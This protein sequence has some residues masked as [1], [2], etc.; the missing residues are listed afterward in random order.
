MLLATVATVAVATTALVIRSVARAQ[1]G[2]ARDARVWALAG[3][4]TAALHLLGAASAT[5]PPPIGRPITLP[6][7]AAVVQAR[8]DP[9]ACLNVNAFVTGTDGTFEGKVPEEALKLAAER[10]AAIKEGSFTVEINDEEP[11]SS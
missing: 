8:L 10:E 11:A 4:E 1:A 5:E 9:V 2:Q 6:V 7:G 3:V